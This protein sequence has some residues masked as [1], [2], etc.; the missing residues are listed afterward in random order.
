[1]GGRGVR[2]VGGAKPPLPPGRPPT[3]LLLARQPRTPLQ[4]EAGDT[5][6]D[7]FPTLDPYQGTLAGDWDAFLTIFVPVTPTPAPSLTPAPTAISYPTC[8]T[9]FPGPSARKKP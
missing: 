5:A 8:R 6:S 4:P 9:T 3:W 1:M 2:G 7:N